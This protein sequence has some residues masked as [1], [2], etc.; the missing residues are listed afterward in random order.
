MLARP[1]S[2]RYR[3]AWT[4]VGGLLPVRAYW[5]DSY[6][7]KQ[8][9]FKMLRMNGYNVVSTPLR[10][11]DGRWVAKGVDIRLTTEL[12]THAFTDSY[13]TAVLVTGDDY[14][15][16]VE[17]VQNEGKRVVVA[18]WSNRAGGRLRSRCDEYVELDEMA[19]A[20]ER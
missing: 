15:R 13:E 12:L 14:L 7:N 17:Q 20:I 2:R 18:S 8:G 3:G 6:K 19:A 9:L 4:T 11:R 5:F 16:A 1:Q 10:K